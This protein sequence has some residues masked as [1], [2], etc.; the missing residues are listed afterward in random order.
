MSKVKKKEKRWHQ[1]RPHTGVQW[2]RTMNAILPKNPVVDTPPRQDRHPLKFRFGCQE[3]KCHTN[4]SGVWKGSL[5]TYEV[6]WGEQA[7]P[8]KERAENET[9][10]G[11]GSAG[12]GRHSLAWGLGSMNL[13]PERVPRLCISLPRRERG[14]AKLKCC[15]SQASKKTGSDSLVITNSGR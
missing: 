6:F 11:G 12:R 4:T 9:V 13:S 5:L 7:A 1:W 15:H 8:R 2:F 14:R 3:W 10:W